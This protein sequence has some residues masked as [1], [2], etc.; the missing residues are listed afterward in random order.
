MTSIFTPLAVRPPSQVWRQA[1]NPEFIEM[2]QEIR[3]GICSERSIT[4]LRS[5]MRPLDETVTRGVVPTILH[6]HRTKVDKVNQEEF[7]KI[8]GDIVEYK[9]EDRSTTTKAEAWLKHLMVCGFCW[10]MWV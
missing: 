5:C 6:P 7:G 10:G 4:L 9:S 1:E 8:E 3:L 2:L